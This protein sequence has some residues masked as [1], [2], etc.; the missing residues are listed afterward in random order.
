MPSVLVLETTPRTPQLGV[1]FR[2]PVAG[3]FIGDGLAVSAYPPAQRALAR[4]AT[5]NRSAIYSFHELPG[6]RGFSFADGANDATWS[7]PRQRFTVEVVDEQ[8]RFLP[9]RFTA[10][11]P[12]RGLFLL[13]CAAVAGST[14]LAVVWSPPDTAP[15]I[16]LHSAPAR[17]VASSFA[18]VRAEL[19]DPVRS[20]PAAWAVV[21]AQ[22]G[23]GAAAF[24]RGVADELGR[25]AIFLPYPQPTDLPGGSSS[26]FPLSP[27]LAEQVWPLRLRAYYRPSATTPGEPPDLCTIMAQ[28]PASLWADT[29]R[30]QPLPELALSFGREL[31]VRTARGGVP[32]PN[33]WVTSA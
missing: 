21:E 31:T 16:P 4:W 23:D 15:A 28:P 2:D 24:A 5:V 17:Q 14:P 27:P 10:D 13:D 18:A 30:S 22:A 6:L 32:L 26:L 8:G 33:L 20:A 12:E 11:L 9:F 7:A 19:W 3:T 1:R 25:L 29:G